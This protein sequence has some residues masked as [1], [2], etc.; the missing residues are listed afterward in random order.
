MVGY[1]GHYLGKVQTSAEGHT[2]HD[3]RGNENNSNKSAVDV[4]RSVNFRNSGGMCSTDGSI[5][6]ALWAK[7]VRL[8]KKRSPTNESH[9]WE[10]IWESTESVERNVNGLHQTD[11]RICLR[12]RSFRL[13]DPFEGEK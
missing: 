12:D 7:I 4:L 5:P 13:W 10:T 11:I 9:K 3:H 8:K 2:H 1:N 6:T